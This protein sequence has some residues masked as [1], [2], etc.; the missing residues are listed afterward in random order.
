M[1]AKLVGRVS[2]YGGAR[3]LISARQI[4]SN[5]NPATESILTHSLIDNTHLLLQGNSTLAHKGYQ[6]GYTR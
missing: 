3:K 2:A 1:T 5:E 6:L 4:N